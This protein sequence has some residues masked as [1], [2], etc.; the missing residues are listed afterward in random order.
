MK[1]LGLLCAMLSISIAAV[2]CQSDSGPQ[3]TPNASPTVSVPTATPTATEVPTPTPTPEPA[4]NCFTDPVAYSDRLSKLESEVAAAMD[5]YDGTWGFALIDLDCEAMAAVNPDYVQYAASAGKFPFIVA[6]VRAVQ[7]GRLDLAD[8]QE[9]LELVLHHS[10]DSSADNIAATV[11]DAE[12][13]AV[14]DLADVSELTTFHDSWRYFFSTPADMARIW[15]AFLDGKMLDEEHTELLMQLASEAEVP[16]AYET[17]PAVFDEPSLRFGQKAGYW[18]SDGTPYHLVGAGFLV[19]FDGSS[20]GFAPVIL[21]IGNDPDL[22]EPQRR[23][24]FPLVV[25]FV[26]SELAVLGAN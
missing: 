10:L 20:A 16:E 1:G 6:S 17:W 19:P 22:L 24:V 8:I 13:Q 2:G 26:L 14:L 12:V 21:M 11:S 4:R 15:A 5:G 9:D 3:A 25:E 18:V 7:E 23:T